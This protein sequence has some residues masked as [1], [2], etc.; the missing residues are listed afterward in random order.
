MKVENMTI[1]IHAPARG[2][3]PE[4]P[5][6]DF[7]FRFQSTHPRG[8]RLGLVTGDTGATPFQSTHPRGVRRGRR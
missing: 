5:D 2:A 3:T 4:H 1:S 8:V 7:A 6:I